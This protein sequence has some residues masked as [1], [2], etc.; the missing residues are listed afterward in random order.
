M[1][2]MTMNLVMIKTPIPDKWVKAR[3]EPQPQPL[4]EPGEVKAIQNIFPEQTIKN[5]YIQ[6]RN[7]W[8]V[9]KKL[10]MLIVYSITV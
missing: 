8:S 1:I 5:M 3:E 10:R 9:R 2:L 7:F 6:L 4:F